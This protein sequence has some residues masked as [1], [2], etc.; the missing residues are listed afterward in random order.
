MFVHVAPES[1]SYHES[2]STLKFGARVSEIT[3][4][5]ASKNIERG[6]PLEIK[7]AQVRCCLRP[8]PRLCAPAGLRC[9]TRRLAPRVTV[10]D[11]ARSLCMCR[12]CAAAVDLGLS[13]RWVTPC[14]SWTWCLHGTRTRGGLEW[15]SEAVC[16]RA[17]RAVQKE[18]QSRVSMLSDENRRKET[19]I[20]QTLEENRRLHAE[21]QELAASNAAMQ[22]QL[23]ELSV[24]PPLPLLA[25][26]LSL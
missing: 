15:R 11:E 17:A 23:A 5:A 18:M 26:S 2:V 16:D 14:D 20:A 10:P 6:S 12:E 19:A 21:K 22:R 7:E 4:G 13:M 24:R 1:T 8:V 9:C 3:L 25:L